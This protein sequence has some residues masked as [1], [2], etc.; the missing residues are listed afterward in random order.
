MLVAHDAVTTNSK[1]AQHK[2]GK[3]V[4]QGRHASHTALLE[5]LPAGDGTPAGTG[6]PTGRGR[7]HGLRQ[8]PLYSGYKGQEPLHA[9]GRGQQTRSMSYLLQQSSWAREGAT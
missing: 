3:L 8:G 2:L 6:R 9:F 7:D 4:I 5:Q 1:K